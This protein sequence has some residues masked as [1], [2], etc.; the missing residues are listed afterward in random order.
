MST[1]CSSRWVANPRAYDPG[2]VG[3]HA[4]LDAGGFRRLV[5]GAVELPRRQR[6]KAI[7]T[8][9]KPAMGQHD[10]P[11]LALAP[12]QPK[13]LQQL[14][15]Q[16]RVAVL[17]ALPLLDPDQH[18]RAVNVID[19]EGGHLRYAQSGAIGGAERG[20]V[21]RARRR[22]EQPPDLLGAQNDWE[23]AGMTGKHEPPRQ[24]W[25]INC[26]GEEEAQRRHRTVD[27]GRLHA[28]L[29]LVN[30]ET[31][32]I[33]GG[34]RVRRSPDKGGE[35]PDEADVVALRLFPQAAHRHVFE[36][37]PAQWTDG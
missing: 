19:L 20:F 11:A 36:H 5:D 22:L 33:L 12:P 35:A 29:D 17:A 6:L 7:A 21:L 26:H 25:P 28:A 14:W 23:L 30:L 2:G 37:A 27:G 24:V 8:R 31:P 16:H 1:S 4:L 32:N 3:R 9:E 13:Q 34:R 10:A 18:A 15:R